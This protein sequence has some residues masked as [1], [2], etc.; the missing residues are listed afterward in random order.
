LQTPQLCCGKIENHVEQARQ[1]FSASLK[2]D[3]KLPVRE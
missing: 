2:K 3:R 1:A